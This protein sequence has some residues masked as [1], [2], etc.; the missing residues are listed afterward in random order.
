MDENILRILTENQNK[1]FV[2]RILNPNEYPTLNNKDGTHSTHSMTW[3]ETGGKFVV[4]PTVLYNDKKELTRHDFKSAWEN[5]RETGN[6][7]EFETS[8][9]ADF[10]SREYKQYWKK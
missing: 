9:E 2:K 1:G 5:V 8:E 6:F 7:I 10:F 3:G 4:F